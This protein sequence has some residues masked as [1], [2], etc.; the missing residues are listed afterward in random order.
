MY[1]QK[2]I[3]KKIMVDVF[4]VTDEISGS[5]SGSISQ[6]YGSADP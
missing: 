3:S 2:V 5:A 6:R 1:L 4:K